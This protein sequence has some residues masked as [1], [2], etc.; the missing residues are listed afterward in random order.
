MHETDYTFAVARIRANETKLLS[1]AQLSQLIAAADAAEVRRLLADRGWRMPEAGEPID[2]A[3]A[4]MADAWA[5]IEACA[6]DP[7]LPAALAVGND[8]TNLK[9][10]IKCVFS[11][12]DPA[13]YYVAPALTDPDVLTKAITEAEFSLLPDHLQAPAQAAYRAIAELHSGQKAELILDKAALETRTDF[14]AK[15]G[16]AL[17][18]RITAL[19]VLLANLKI[20]LR[21]R[22]MGKSDEFALDA[23]AAGDPDPAALYAACR[24]PKSAAEYLAS[25]PYAYL[26]DAAGESFTALEKAGDNA[27]VAML[28]DV[29]YEIF[30]P[31]PL[32]A[33]FY[34]K[35]AETKNARI[36]LSAKAAGVPAQSIAERVREIYV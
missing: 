21:C 4:A 15:S 34:A 26:A 33:Y 27:I 12:L 23:M 18:Q 24:D 29:K 22:R 36:I 3:E 17:L 31:D 30:G 11:D 28:Q 32:V 2:P 35:V 25:T 5:L 1:P 6:P 10:A 20:A 9:A 7:A 14:A 16:S 13:G 19:T 8:F